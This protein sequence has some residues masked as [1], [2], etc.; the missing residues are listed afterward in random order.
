MRGAEEWRGS[1]RQSGYLFEKSCGEGGGRE[2]WQALARRQCTPDRYRASRASALRYAVAASSPSPSLSSCFTCAAGPWPLS[3]ERCGE[4]GRVVPC[5]QQE[6]SR[7]RGG[8][9]RTCTCTARSGGFPRGVF[10]KRAG[11]DIWRCTT[12]VPLSPHRLP[13]GAT[14]GETLQ[15]GGKAPRVDGRPWPWTG[16]SRRGHWCRGDRGRGGVGGDPSRAPAPGRAWGGGTGCRG[17]RAHAE[18]RTGSAT[19][20]RVRAPSTA[21]GVTAD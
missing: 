12:H 20:G 21:D 18:E 8:R 11:R 16:E 17:R 9:T 14:T 10:Q 7:T 15:R 6:S 1:R 5:H 2:R 4:C 19:R 13:G 3:C